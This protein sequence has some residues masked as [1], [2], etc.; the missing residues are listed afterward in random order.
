MV[1]CLYSSP[2]TNIPLSRLQCTGNKDRH[3][4]AGGGKAA[5]LV[6]SWGKS[7]EPEQGTSTVQGE[8]GSEDSDDL[9]GSI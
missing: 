6:M 1:V 4:L 9:R 3:P 5:V 7:G 2:L 8:K